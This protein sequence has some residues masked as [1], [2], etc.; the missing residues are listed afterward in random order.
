MKGGEKGRG[1]GGMVA[2]SAYSRY[3]ERTN[4]SHTILLTGGFSC[5]FNKVLPDYINHVKHT[6]QALGKSYNFSLKSPQTPRF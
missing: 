5:R 6:D 1:E 4:T 2:C 3:L